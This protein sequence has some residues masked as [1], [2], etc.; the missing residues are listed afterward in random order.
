MKSKDFALIGAAVV[1]G[2]I[3]SILIGKFVFNKSSTGKS[4]EVVPYISSQFPKADSRYFNNNSVDPT[5][6]INIGNNQN[7][8]PFITSNNSQ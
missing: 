2:A 5:T 4:V 7:N 3:F 8:A 6:F 1:F